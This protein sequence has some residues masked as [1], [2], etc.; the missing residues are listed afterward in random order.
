MV[1]RAMR[2]LSV[3]AIKNFFE[4]GEGTADA[5]VKVNQIDGEAKRECGV[6]GTEKLAPAGEGHGVTQ[7]RVA[8][9]G[10]FYRGLREMHGLGEMGDY[11]LAF[12]GYGHYE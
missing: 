9:Y 11:L 3:L 8:I 5:E 7:L 4:G 10:L 6:K 2:L 1:L 12:G